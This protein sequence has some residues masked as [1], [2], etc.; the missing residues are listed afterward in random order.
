MLNTI[1]ILRSKFSPF[2]IAIP[3][4]GVLVTQV[5]RTKNSE[6]RYQQLLKLFGDKIF[7][8]VI[9]L[10]EKVEEAND[11]E[12]ISGYDFAPDAKG[13]MAYAEVVKEIIERVGTT[14]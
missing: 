2:G 12:D 4:L 13:V 1:T 9:P 14:A 6:E 5:R 7:K 8:S 3:I 11:Q 10:N